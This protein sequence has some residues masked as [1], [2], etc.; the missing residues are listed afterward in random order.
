MQ[1]LASALAVDG[2][3][4]PIL[5]HMGELIFG[6]IVFAILYIIVARVV[7]PRLEG[8]FAESTAAIEGGIA[9]AE[10]AQAE[11]AQALAD[12]KAQL[13][14]ARG[15]AQ[16][17]REDARAEGSAI[18]AEMRERAQVEANRITAA[19]QQQIQAE[20]QQAVVQL[21][22]EVGTLATSL[23]SKI[24]GESLESEARQSGVVDRFLAELEASES[25]R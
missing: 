13:A 25:G 23:A 6:L 22:S 8:V 5:P 1:H 14:D 3:S 2:E 11:A 17:I 12:Y 9:K 18:I 15:E 21:R 7:V 19:A 4:P 24:V 16:K 10:A 20:R